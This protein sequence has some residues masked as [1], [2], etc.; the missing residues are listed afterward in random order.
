M[1]P[2]AE[3]EL[4]ASCRRVSAIAD[5]WTLGLMLFALGYVALAC[6]A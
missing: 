4:I 6:L 5:R 3:T 1:T 2:E